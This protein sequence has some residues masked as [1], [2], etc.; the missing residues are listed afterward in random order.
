MWFPITDF[1][2]QLN[3]E[4]RGDTFTKG[5]FPKSSHPN[6]LARPNQAGFLLS[7]GTVAAGAG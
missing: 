3:L 1:P 6:P 2:A 7:T 5:A 4:S